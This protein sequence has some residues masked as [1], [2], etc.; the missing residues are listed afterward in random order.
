MSAISPFVDIDIHP[1]IF[2]EYDMQIIELSKIK[3]I[4]KVK[5]QI[6]T[7]AIKKST[8]SKTQF[9]NMNQ[10]INY[11]DDKKLPV[12][13]IVPNKY[14]DF[15]VDYTDGLVYTTKWINGEHLTLNNK[16]YLLS[17]ISLLGQLHSIG[18]Y[19][20]KKNLRFNY[21]DEIA[22]KNSWIKSIEWLKRYRNKLKMQEVRSTFE[23]IYFTYISFIIDWACEALE[24]LNNWIIE[25]GSIMNLRRTICHGKFHHRNIIVTPENKKYLVDFDHVSYDTPV[26]DLAFFIRNYILNKECRDWIEECL[27][28]YQ[29][30]NTLLSEEKKLLSIFLLFPEKIITL[31][32]NYYSREKNLAEDF[33]LKKLQVRWAQIRELIWFVDRHGWLYE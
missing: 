26:R 13:K 19:F 2:K 28:N 6:G 31:G 27:V 4:T 8:M 30:I 29:H 10:V 14:G 21:L 22:I 1:H 23:H 20:K 18:L 15:Y 11:L 24:Q 9:Q 12:S 16:E 32:Q 17:A 33:Y 3:S 5:S 25:Y 7:F